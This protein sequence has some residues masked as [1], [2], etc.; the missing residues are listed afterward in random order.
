MGGRPQLPCA[1][2]LP[3]RR[4]ICHTALSACAAAAQPATPAAGRGACGAA[5]SRCLSV[6][7]ARE[8]SCFARAHSWR[9]RT[10]AGLR[11]S[12]VNGSGPHP[13]LLPLP[14][15]CKHAI[16]SPSSSAEQPAPPCLPSLCCRDYAL[17][18]LAQDRLAGE[19]RQQRLADGCYVRWDGTLAFYFSEVG[20]RSSRLLLQLGCLRCSAHWSPGRALGCRLGGCA[21]AG[22]ALWCVWGVGGGSRGTCAQSPPPAFENLGRPAARI[23]RRGSRM[24]PLAPNAGRPARPA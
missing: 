7:A 15:C 8:L 11:C 24:L 6:P 20:R 18:D 21:A 3:R 14:A 13:S 22:A 4:V 23:V 17:G 1:P 2:S 9:L 5:I 10:P 12:H 19:G 16:A